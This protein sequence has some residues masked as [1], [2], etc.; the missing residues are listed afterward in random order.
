MRI[1][2][3]NELYSLVSIMSGYRLDGRGSISGRD[4]RCFLPHNI[5]T[6]SAAHPDSYSMGIGVLSLW[7]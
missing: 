2:F 4:K 6:G 3:Y 7:G 5:Q 1:R